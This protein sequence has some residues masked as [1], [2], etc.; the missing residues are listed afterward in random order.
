MKAFL[1]DWSITYI[2][3]FLCSTALLRSFPFY[4]SENSCGTTS[5]RTR[6]LASSLSRS[7]GSYFLWSL[8]IFIQKI[9]ESFGVVRK[10]RQRD[11]LQT[12]PQLQSFIGGLSY[13][14][15]RAHDHRIDAWFLCLMV[16][17]RDFTEKKKRKEGNARAMRSYSQAQETKE[18]VMTRKKDP[19]IRSRQ[20]AFVNIF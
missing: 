6:P 18:T 16:D 13:Y 10:K 11:N 12:D 8:V 1:Q 9:R 3:C 15:S 20:T 5:L 7:G 2:S 19:A 4:S 14:L 17:T